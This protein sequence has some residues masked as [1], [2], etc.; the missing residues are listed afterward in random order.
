MGA[1]KEFIFEIDV[2]AVEVEWVVADAN[3]FSSEG[4]VGFEESGM[5]GKGAVF[6]DLSLDFEHKGQVDILMNGQ[7]S[8][9]VCAY[10]P[11]LHGALADG[12]VVFVVVRGL[13]PCGEF[14]IEL[15]EGLG[16]IEMDQFV[17]EV[18]LH[19][20]EESFDFSARCGV[21]D[22]GVE[23]DRADKGADPGELSGSEDLTVI[24]V[25]AFWDA[26]FLTGLF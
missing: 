7:E 25:Q 4:A 10:E 19:G 18:V 16:R 14:F 13:A 12:G 9:M 17:K 22:A 2:C 15:G 20:F 24:A 3:F 21:A 23:D 26:A 8:D 6:F 11:F 1:S 5:E